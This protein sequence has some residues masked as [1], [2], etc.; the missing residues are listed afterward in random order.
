M[1][2]VSHIKGASFHHHHHVDGE[3][4]AGWCSSV[5]PPQPDT[6]TH[7]THSSSIARCVASSFFI[8]LLCVA[9]SNNPIHEFK[10]C[11]AASACLVPRAG[12]EISIEA[13]PAVRVS[14]DF[15]HPCGIEISR[16]KGTLG[17]SERDPARI[18]QTVVRCSPWELFIQSLDRGNFG[19]R[20]V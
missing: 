2:I 9:T 8:A 20:A 12:I 7:S 14:L 17:S 1:H 13:C 4:R 19:C 10:H 6:Y 16:R 11:H 3:V 5:V 15:A 18:H